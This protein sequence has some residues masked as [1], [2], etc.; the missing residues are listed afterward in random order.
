MSTLKIFKVSIMLEIGTEVNG[1]MKAWT[2]ADAMNKI[3]QKYPDIS[4]IN[5][6]EEEDELTEIPLYCSIL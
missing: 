5:W 6:I 1:W 4:Y 2:L 3:A